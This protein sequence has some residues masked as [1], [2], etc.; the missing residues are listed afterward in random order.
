MQTAQKP[1]S[2][3]VLRWWGFGIIGIGC[4]FLALFFS[5]PSPFGDSDL[6]ATLPFTWEEEERHAEERTEE[7]QY[8]AR[9]RQNFEQHQRDFNALV[10]QLLAAS[11]QKKE[12][13]LTSKQSPHLRKMQII[14][15]T[16]LKQQ[17]VVFIVNPN[18]DFGKK[19]TAYQSFNVFYV[20]SRQKQ[21]EW[22][23]KARF[24]LADNWYFFTS[25]PSWEE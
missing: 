21:T 8:E 13:R 22:E 6:G 9:V 14:E 4:F 3:K 16:G 5:L 19:P 2:N 17:S 12:T 15:V 11:V 20:Y 24:N 18:N 25:I 1:P 7:A 10:K 23:A